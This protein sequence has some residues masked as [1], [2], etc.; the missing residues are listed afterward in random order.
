MTDATDRF[1]TDTPRVG[2]G[3]VILRTTRA[4]QHQYEVLLVRRAKEPAKGMWSLPGGAVE[5]GETVR[6]AAQREV[7]EETGLHV[8]IG[9]PFTAV[10]AIIHDE[11]GTVAFHFVIV[12]VLA[13]ASPD[14]V[15]APAD[16]IDAVR[17]TVPE[18]VADV[19]PLTE[20]VPPVVQMAVGLL[21]AGIVRRPAV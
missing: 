16:D 14:A 9:A 12:E 2:V 6:D 13:F 19:R 17:W 21:D 10:D 15:P 1:Y 8:E 20:Q 5:L 3:V 4:G 18:Q 11:D 7:K